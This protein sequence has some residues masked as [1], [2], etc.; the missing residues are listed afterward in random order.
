M[1][2]QVCL[3]IVDRRDLG[4]LAIECALVDVDPLPVDRHVEKKEYLSTLFFFVPS[5][6]FV[7]SIFSRL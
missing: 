3:V 6:L 5:F 2:D 4:I 1:L 7:I